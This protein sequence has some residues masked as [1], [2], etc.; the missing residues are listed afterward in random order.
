MLIDIT[1][2]AKKMQYTYDIWIFFNLV[3]I[4]KKIHDYILF[5]ENK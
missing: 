5:S 2:D 4:R 3:G 1:G